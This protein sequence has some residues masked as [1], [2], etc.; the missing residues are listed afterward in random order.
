MTD[1]SCGA[2][3]LRIS[4]RKWRQLITELGHRGGGVRESG[5]FLLA[6]ADNDTGGPDDLTVRRIAFYDDLDAEC[7][8]GGISLAG[9][10][11]DTLWTICR[12]AGLRVIADIHTHPGGWTGQ[13]RT[14]AAN[15]M[16]AHSGHLALIVGHFA[17][18]PTLPGSVAVHLYLGRHEWKH[19]ADG[20]G[21]ARTWFTRPRSCQPCAGLIA[22]LRAP[23]IHITRRSGRRQKPIRT[24]P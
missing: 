5:A 4:R 10:G 13:S 11:Y 14:D 24:N 17:T 6:C 15:P 9:S 8:T 7:L 23:L 1:R 3:L 2:E 21:I 12:E 16:M 18:Q 20:S 19:L 22:S